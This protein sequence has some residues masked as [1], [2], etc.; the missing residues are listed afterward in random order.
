MEK[1]YL[2]NDFQELIDKDNKELE[3]IIQQFIT[4]IMQLKSSIKNNLDSLVLNNNGFQIDRKNEK[5][6]K[7]VLKYSILV[8]NKI[9]TKEFF[10]KLKLN[11]GD[12]EFWAKLESVAQISKSFYEET[13]FMRIL[14]DEKFEKIINDIFLNNILS[15]GDIVE[16]EEFNQEQNMVVIKV[17]E[18]AITAIIEKCFNKIQFIDEC[19]L[20]F[21]LGDRKVLMLWSIIKKHEQQLIPKYLFKRIENISADVRQLNMRINEISSAIKQ[22]QIKEQ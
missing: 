20:R 12:T 9:D 4:Y 3:G 2:V 17:L 16:S 1:E 8:G 22:S 18:F 5:I 19:R 14:S 13:N 10:G 21:D 6:F 7:N 11:K 15:Y